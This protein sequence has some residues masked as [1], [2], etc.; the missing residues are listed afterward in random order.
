MIA[1]FSAFLSCPAFLP[2]RVPAYILFPVN[3]IYI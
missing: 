2:G 3:N 1:K